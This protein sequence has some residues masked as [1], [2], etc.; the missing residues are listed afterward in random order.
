MIDSIPEFQ[1]LRRSYEEIADKIKTI[2][3]QPKTESLGESTAAQ[4]KAQSTQI[5]IDEDIKSELERISSL[6]ESVSSRLTNLVNFL[7]FFLKR[8][9]LSS[10]LNWTKSM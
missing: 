2:E 8:G 6:L 5:H 10:V 4:A 1:E 3:S 7:F 9:R